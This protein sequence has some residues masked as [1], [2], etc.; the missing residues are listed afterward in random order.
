MGRPKKEIKLKEPIRI[1]KKKLANGNQSLYLDYYH[2]GE[3]KYEFLRLYLVPEINA[4][5][6]IQNE[7]TLNA[8]NF[9]KSQ[10]II[11]MNNKLAGIKSN[12]TKQ[13][14]LF[15]DWF[16]HFRDVKVRRGDF[17]PASVRHCYAIVRALKAFRPKAT[18][19][20]IDRDFLLEYIDFLRNE[21]VSHLNGHMAKGTIRYHVSFIKGAV[22]MAEEE[23]IIPQSP[24][25]GL[26]GLIPY[27]GGLNA[28]R[29]YLTIDEIKKLRDTPCRYEVLKSAF[30]FSCFCGLRIS[31]VRNLRW[32]DIVQDGD[33]YRASIIQY[34][35]KQP[36]YIPLNHQALSCMPDR[37]NDKP[38]DNI[39]KN[40][41]T[42]TTISQAI[43]RWAKDAGINKK[44]TYHVSRHSF[45]TT[46]L[47]LGADLYTTSKLLGHSN[48]Q[49][50]QIYAKIVDR[51]KDDAVDLF[52]TAF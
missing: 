30:L 20:D 36:L 6:K 7:E 43:K 33:R 1:R 45:A 15:T 48:V 38:D 37:G 31:D 29:E 17:S 32:K 2:E 11:D 25:R 22:N 8:A 52:D 16:E 23:R 9:I 5:A 21:Y 13:K 41:P 27:K 18:I 12:P 28:P 35:T 40:L 3:R 14:M 24:V 47:T 39:F 19:K 44:V 4:Q 49:T 26:R 46:S 34:K 42:P 50:T 10:R 51:K